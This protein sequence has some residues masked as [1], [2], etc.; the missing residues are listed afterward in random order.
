M[1][2]I[3]T[4]ITSVSRRSRFKLSRY[5]QEESLRLLLAE[6]ELDTPQGHVADYIPE[7]RRANADHQGISLC[8]LD[9]SVVSA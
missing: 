9:G 3:V 1:E 8:F 4:P 2:S 7:L 5:G 6:A